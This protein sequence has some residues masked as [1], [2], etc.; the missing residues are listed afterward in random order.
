LHGLRLPSTRILK[1]FLPQPDDHGLTA[2]AACA[3]LFDMSTHPL[4]EYRKKLGL[5]LDEIAARAGTTKS[6]VSRIELYQISPP[7]ALV[8]RLV[9]A[10]DG[11][12][13]PDDFMPRDYAPPR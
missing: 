3:T 4:R 13:R 8:G 12:L 10:T 7:L 11:W 6:S 2:I 5:S 1:L 9:H